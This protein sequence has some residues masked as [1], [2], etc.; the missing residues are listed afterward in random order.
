[1][2]LQQARAELD[3][4]LND[5]GAET[6]MPGLATEE[7]GVCILV[8]DGYLNVNLMID[9]RSTDLLAWSTVG[10]L[11]EEGAEQVLRRL[12]RA[13]LFWGETDGGIIGLMEEADNVVFSIRRPIEEIDLPYLRAL[14]ET[15]VLRA[16][17]FRGVLNGMPELPDE[18]PASEQPVALSGAIRG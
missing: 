2:D 16:E 5:F 8:F 13:N 7:N 1:M 4:L 9:P 17:Q 11:P 6:G 12:L 3:R 15:V 10:V 14:V 18:A